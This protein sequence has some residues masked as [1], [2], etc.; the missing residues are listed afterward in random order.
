VAGAT[1]HI[2]PAVYT[3]FE[4]T[5][6]IP[7]EGGIYV[8][9]EKPA[10]SPA[11]PYLL[12]P[13][14]SPLLLSDNQSRFTFWKFPQEM[15]IPHATAIPSDIGMSFVGWSV[16]E[17]LQPGQTIVVHT[18]WRIDELLQERFGWI[19]GPFVH[20]LDGSGERISN[21]STI[22]IPPSQWR[23]GFLMISSLEVHL[24]SNSEGP[25]Q[26][27]TGVFDPNRMVDA[28][29]RIPQADGSNEFTRIIPLA[30]E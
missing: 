3:G 24:P 11:I 16:E 29:F 26:M 18:Y 13:A 4:D 10:Q 1:G 8:Q 27:L 25:Y 28:I 5:I 15:S 7:K 22:F 6:I 19:F 30:I 2:T 14:I 23:Q 9:F 20:T 12:R 21:E 17:S